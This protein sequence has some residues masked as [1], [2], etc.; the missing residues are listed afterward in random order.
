MPNDP[1]INIGGREFPL[2]GVVRAVGGVVL[3]LLLMYL[4]L[5]SFYRVDA[6][7]RAVV[8]R[9]GTYLRTNGPGPHFKIP[10]FDEYHI[11]SVQERSL[12][13]PVK[14]DPD[15]VFLGITKSHG[16]VRGESELLV[17]T[18]GLNQG[19]V[20]WSV[21]WKVVDP[22]AFLFAF[23]QDADSDHMQKVIESASVSVMNRLVGDYSLEEIRAKK[24]AEISEA[25]KDSLQKMLDRYDCGVAVTGLQLQRVTPPR[26]VEPSYNKVVAAEQNREKL[27]NEG[28]K[29]RNKLLPKAEASKDKLIQEAKGYASRRRAEA[30]GE[31]QALRDKFAA[32]REAPEL[33]QRRMYL[34]AMEEVI[35]NSG[36]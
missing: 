36:E 14:S 16:A 8:L 5:D 21:Q 29:E 10:W 4:A 25:A 34:E 17:L 30:K 28:K 31:I 1:S 35:S 23:H 27:E 13:L 20:E 24:R 22:R 11:I 26:E 18:G 9:R 12:R 3:G 7:D 33:T 19:I 6:S 32:Y 15:E 2:A